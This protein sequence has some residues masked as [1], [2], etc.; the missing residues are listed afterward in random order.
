MATEIKASA[1]TET[2]KNRVDK[3]RQRGLV[4]C[5][6][7]APG[8][9]NVMLTIDHLQVSRLYFAGELA[10][11][12]V[13]LEFPGGDRRL[14]TAIEVQVHPVSDQVLHVDFVPAATA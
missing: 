13:E 7:Y 1:R 11:K 8:E 12:R 3:L 6:Y 9:K 4:P 10:G 14:V 5:I 2:G